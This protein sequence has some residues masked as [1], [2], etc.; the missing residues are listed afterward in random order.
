MGRLFFP[1]QGLTAA[2]ACATIPMYLLGFLQ[3]FSVNNFQV[4]DDFDW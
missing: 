3:V 1:L 4:L 2:A